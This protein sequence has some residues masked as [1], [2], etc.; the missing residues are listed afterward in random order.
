[1]KGDF[2]ITLNFEILK[3][4]EHADS[5]GVAGTR[6]T[7]GLIKDV[8]KQDVTTL[9]RSVLTSGTRFVGWSS[10][11]NSVTEKRDSHASNRPTNAKTGRLRLVRA[12]AD[13]YYGTAEELDGDP[14]ELDGRPVQ[15]VQ[16]KPV[17]FVG[18]E[19]LDAIAAAKVLAREARRLEFLEVLA[20]IGARPPRHSSAARR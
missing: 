11:W 2:E 10:L 16:I 3:E 8:P 20:D 17:D 9:N 1:M 6:V 4:P 14:L 18:E 19:M 15:H 5:G 7:L 13:L 12:G